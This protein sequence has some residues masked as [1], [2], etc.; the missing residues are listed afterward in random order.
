MSGGD[1]RV[2]GVGP[3]HVMPKPPLPPQVRGE[4]KLAFKDL[5]LNSISEVQQL[6]TQ[7][8]QAIKDLAAG[9]VEDVSQALIAVEKADIAFSTMMQ[10]RNKI[11]EAYQ[12]VMRMS[13]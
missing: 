7:A 8:D 3:K 5:L 9:E 4:E 12:E 10:M 2:P 11:I 1:L 13:V 6:Q